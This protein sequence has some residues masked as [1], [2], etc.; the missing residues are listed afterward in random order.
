MAGAP[1]FHEDLNR[2]PAVKAGSERSFGL[3]FAAVFTVIGLWPLFR[4]GEVRG[5]ALAAAAFFLGAGLWAPGWLGPLNRIWFRFGLALGRVVNP[6]VMGMLFFL[7]ITPMAV[8]ARLFGKDPLRLRRDGGA[9]SYW[10]ERDPPGP[11]PESLQR[12]F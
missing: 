2:E 8:L 3:V 9:K 1:S 6:L 12:Q 7:V 4:G 11:E 5:E 10:I